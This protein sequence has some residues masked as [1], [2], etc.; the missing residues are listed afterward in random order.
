M[1]EALRDVSRSFGLAL[2]LEDRREFSQGLAEGWPSLDL[3]RV[4]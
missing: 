4:L 2:F 3:G 1:S